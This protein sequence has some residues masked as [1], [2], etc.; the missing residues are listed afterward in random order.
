MQKVNEIIGIVFSCDGNALSDSDTPKTI[1][2]WDSMTHIILLSS[3]EEEFDVVF[4]DEEMTSIHSIG[5]IREK[6]SGN[7]TGI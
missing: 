2:A 6:I 4:S 1:K 7:T 3:L 5:E